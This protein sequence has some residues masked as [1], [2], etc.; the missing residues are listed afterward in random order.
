MVAIL[1]TM[2]SKN[3]RYFHYNI[4]GCTNQIQ[5]VQN[6]WQAKS[7]EKNLLVVKFEEILT[8]DIKQ[9][10]DEVTS[11]QEDVTKDWL[12]DENSDATQ[13]KE[14]L[15]NLSDRLSVCVSQMDEYRNY[16]KE[17]RV[18]RHHRLSV[19]AISKLIISN[20]LS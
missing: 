14:C 18:C 10:F 8:E 3:H 5:A 13:V 1:S 2:S 17:F 4:A 7:E 15:V 20:L 9:L 16:Q 11:I 12:I 19:T 6:T